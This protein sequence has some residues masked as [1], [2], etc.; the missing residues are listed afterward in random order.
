[1]KRQTMTVQFERN[2]TRAAFLFNDGQFKPRAVRSAKAYRRQ[3]KH[4]SRAE[5]MS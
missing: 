2:R 1:M 5:N 4:R 3:D